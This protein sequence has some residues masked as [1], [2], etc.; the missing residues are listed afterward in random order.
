M[1]DVRSIIIE[2]SSIASVGCVDELKSLCT[3]AKELNLGG[4]KI[5]SWETVSCYSVAKGGGKG[6]GLRGLSPPNI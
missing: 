5:H 2:S 3:K 4:N 1:Q 6:A